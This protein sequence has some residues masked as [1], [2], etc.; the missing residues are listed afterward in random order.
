MFKR[1]EIYAQIM[2]PNVNIILPKIL[3]TS[4]III[5]YIVS[6]FDFSADAIFS[7]YMK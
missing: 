4:D 5:K 3:I 2:I 7:N 1:R 6:M